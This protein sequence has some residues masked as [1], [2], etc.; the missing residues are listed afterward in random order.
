MR[1]AFFSA[2]LL[3]VA[4]AAPAEE[5]AIPSSYPA[6][7]YASMRQK[8]PFALA[9]P[10]VAPVPKQ[11]SFTQDLV[12]DGF[13]TMVVDGEDLPWVSIK[14][15]DKRE[16]FTL[17]GNEPNAEGISIASV[18]QSPSMEKTTVMLKKGDEFGSVKY[19]PAALAAPPPMAQGH[20]GQPNALNRPPGFPG[21]Q[22][23]PGNQ[24]QIP[25]PNVAPQTNVA[26]APGAQAPG[27]AAPANTA[28]R[29][30]VI[31]NRP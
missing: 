21:Q 26:P 13:S 16:Q 29:V 27:A 18:E 9:T 19:D 23:R 1:A 12:I 14:D 5:E 15:R 28:R 22:I 30:R 7:R 10:V 31:T 20:P 2:L 24:I 3:A 8:S 11:A 4:T 17:W 6:E 25:R